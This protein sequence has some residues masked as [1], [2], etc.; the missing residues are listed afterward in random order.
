MLESAFFV[1]RVPHGALMPSRTSD[2][3]D[4]SRDPCERGLYN[5][6]NVKAAVDAS[7]IEY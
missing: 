3:K 5:W 1:S 2:A 6:A 7:G 4:A